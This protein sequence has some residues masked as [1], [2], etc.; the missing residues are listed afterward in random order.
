MAEDVAADVVAAKLEDVKAAF[1]DFQV[2]H[3][4]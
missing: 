4:A 3:D 2:A 1:G